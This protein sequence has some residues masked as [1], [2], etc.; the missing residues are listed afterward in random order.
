MVQNDV[1]VAVH[2]HLRLT[3]R[4]I[5]MMCAPQSGLPVSVVRYRVPSGLST[6][7]ACGFTSTKART[8]LFS[9]GVGTSVTS[10]ARTTVLV[11]LKAKNGRKNVK[12]G[13]YQPI[14]SANR[15]RQRPTAVYAHEGPAQNGQN[16]GN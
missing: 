10:A 7:T 8:S 3:A 15:R 11:Y 13:P 14:L 16:G 9:A 6:I 2:S 4:V 1:E 12:S 5:E